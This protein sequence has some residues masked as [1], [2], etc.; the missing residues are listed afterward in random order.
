MHHHVLCSDLLMKTSYCQIS[1]TTVVSEPCMMS[2]IQ[3]RTM[4]IVSTARE[5]HC[6]VSI[7]E[8]GEMSA[9]DQTG[10][11]YRL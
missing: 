2:S 7:K 10:L 8:E 11:H 3:M 9:C 5:D 4:T 6:R 1:S